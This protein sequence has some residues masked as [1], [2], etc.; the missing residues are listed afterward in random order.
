MT[1]RRYPRRT[2]LR[3]TGAVL[4]GTSLS[5][6]TSAQT[7]RRFRRQTSED[8]TRFIMD[9]RDGLDRDITDTDLDIVHSLEPVNLLAVC[10]SESDIRRLSA[11]YVQDVKITRSRSATQ[12]VLR[13]IAQND[14]ELETLYPFQWDKREMDIPAVHEFTEG[15]GTRVAVIDSGVQADHPDLARA[16]DTEQ[17]RNFTDDGYGIGAAY[18]G[19]VPAHGTGVAGVIAADPN[20]GGLLGT[21]P[22]AEIVDCRVFPVDDGAFIGDYLAAIVYSA[23]IGCDVANLSLGP[24]IE[25]DDQQRI[26]NRFDAARVAQYAD[27]AGMLLTV[28]AGNNAIDL[29]RFP[30]IEFLNRRNVM[31]VSATGPIGFAW[32]SGEPD[33]TANFEDPI[34]LELPVTEPAAYSNYGEGIINVSAPGG[35]YDSVARRDNVPGWHYDMLPQCITDVQRNETGEFQFSNGYNWDMGTSLAAPQV[36]GAAALIKSVDPSLTAAEIRQTIEET[37]VNVRGIDPDPFHGSGFLDPV[38]A[39]EAVRE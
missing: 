31:V 4:G 23:D 10:G 12:T 22:E 20:A 39:V 27:D 16:V 25:A 29:R 24:R 11:P 30:N 35:N 5:G 3:T 9:T 26:V 14:P 34:E 17:S 36:A 8:I 28:A 38:A 1:D 19:F 18:G 33:R 6:L 37:A 13:Q 21:A 7:G 15:L 2:I 32:P